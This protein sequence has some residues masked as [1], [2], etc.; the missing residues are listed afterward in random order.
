MI[1]MA[2]ASL[3]EPKKKKY[4]RNFFGIS[5]LLEKNFQ[6]DSLKNLEFKVI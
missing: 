1:W 5:F 4:Q 2:Q 3:L 6:A